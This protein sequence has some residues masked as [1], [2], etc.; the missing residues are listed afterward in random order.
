MASVL[1][2]SEG[3]PSLGAIEGEAEV[4]YSFTFFS[5]VFVSSVFM[6]LFELH[7]HSALLWSEGRPSLGAIEGEASGQFE[8]ITTSFLIS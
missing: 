4:F 6:Y 2:L 7:T 3:G 1:L 5:Y 8:W